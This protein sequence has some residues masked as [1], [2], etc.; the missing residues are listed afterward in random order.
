MTKR[1]NT[2][3]KTKPKQWP[4]TPQS[5]ADNISKLSPE[6]MESLFNQMVACLVAGGLLDG[7]RIAALDGSKLPTPPS[8]EGCG[9]L[10]QTRSVKV[11]GQKERATEEYYVYGWKVLVLIDVHTRLPLAM[12]VVKIEEYEGGFLVSLLEQAQRNLGTRGRIRTIVIDRGYLDG[13]DLWQVH[14]QGIIFV[15]V[16]RINLRIM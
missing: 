12:K 13:E 10:K 1:Q 7:Q 6:Q 16:I 2:Q 3:H 5:L 11:K 9:K 4:L 14:Q 8:Y 15:E